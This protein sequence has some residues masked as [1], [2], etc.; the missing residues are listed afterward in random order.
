MQLSPV[1]RFQILS[2]IHTYFSIILNIQNVNFDY[3]EDKQL[4]PLAGGTDTTDAAADT[5]KD[6]KKRN[7]CH[8]CKKKVGLT[9]R[10]ALIFS[11]LA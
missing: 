4:F 9:G 2:N 6:K 5:S 1:F 11:F 10:F 3:D 8:T 7:R